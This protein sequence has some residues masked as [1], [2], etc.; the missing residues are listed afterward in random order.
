MSDT[1]GSGAEF[2]LEI[3]C[4]KGALSADAASDILESVEDVRPGNVNWSGAMLMLPSPFA[5]LSWS[6]EGL[7]ARAR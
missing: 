2:I 1:S 4:I 5:L 3:V 7:S 6:G